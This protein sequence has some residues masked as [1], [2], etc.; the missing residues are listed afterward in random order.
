MIT[1]KK[2]VLT[3]LYVRMSTYINF[4]PLKDLI[5]W[6]AKEQ[7]FQLLQHAYIDF[8]YRHGRLF[9]TAAN[10]S[11]TVATRPP[12]ISVPALRFN[13]SDSQKSRSRS[14]VVS[15]GETVTA[16]SD[17]LSPPTSPSAS[18]K[19]REELRPEDLR[20]TIGRTYLFEEAMVHAPESRLWT[21]M[22]FWEDL[23]LDT[24]AQERDVLGMSL[25][26]MKAGANSKLFIAFPN[27]CWLGCSLMAYVLRQNVF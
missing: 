5:L 1:L 18:S 8:R 3:L 19:P 23:F 10:V 13:I 26:H 12:S 11:S 25:S 15:S 17:S 24:V 21:N 27:E 22:Q 9:Q 4:L 7:S 16:E 14:S 6:S 2:D 20:A